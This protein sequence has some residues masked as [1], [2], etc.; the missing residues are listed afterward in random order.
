MSPEERLCPHVGTVSFAFWEVAMPFKSRAQKGYLYAREPAVAKRF[1]A[2][3]PKGAKL[4]ARVK[5]K[6]RSK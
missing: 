5:P 4:P 1:Q 6:R 3:T 2:E